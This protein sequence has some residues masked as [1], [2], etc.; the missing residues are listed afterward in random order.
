MKQLSADVVVIGGGATGAGVLRDA[1]MRGFSAVLLERADIAQGTSS[2]FH[3]LLHSGGRYVVSDPHS[4]T[5]CAEENAI[6]RR[7]NADAIEETGGLFAMPPGDPDDF[8]DKFRDGAIK[9]KV[10]AEE[11]TIKE[12]LRLE[13]RLNPRVKRVF[14]VEDGCV[15]GWRLVW[16]ALES[17]REY[18]AKILPYH[19]ATE[20]V[21]RNGVVAQVK[22]V[23]QKTNDQ[24]SIDCRYIVNAGGPWA[25]SIAQMAGAPGVDVVPGRGIMIGMNHRLVNHVVNRLCVP[26]DGDIIVPG[27]TICVIGTTDQAE[28]HPDFLSIKPHEV[29]KMLDKGEDLIP[30]F[31]KARAVHIWSGARPLLKDSRVKATD[32]RHMSRGMAIIDHGERDGIK[33]LLTVAGGKFTTY[34]LMAQ[35]VVDVMCEH[36]GENRP[37]RTAEEAVPSARSGHHEYVSNRLAEVEKELATTQ[38][39]CECELVTRDTIARQFERVP[40]SNFDDMRRQLRVGMGPCQ[41]TFCG[42]RSAGIAHESRRKHLPTEEPAVAADATT[43]MLRLFYANRMQGIAPILYGS[44]LTEIALQSWMLESNLDL[45]RLPSPSSNAKLT[46]GDMALIHGVPKDAKAEDCPLLPASLLGRRPHGD[47]HEKGREVA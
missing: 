40:K 10:P 1:A 32:T 7:I 30:G 35:E 3:G 26:A 8:G 47:P 4:A 42:L 13:P 25:G 23:D 20:I 34:R 33:G 14:R 12:A 43:T 38:I 27:H 15:D 5:Q 37:C 2:R 21:V 11:I 9:T 44:T 24:V 29:Q 6:V 36:L 28:Q 17:G 46:T 31:R 22:A 18:G 16:G 41:G 45:N 39:I 19:L